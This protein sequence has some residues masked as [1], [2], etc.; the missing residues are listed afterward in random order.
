MAKKVR[1]SAAEFAEK[2]I[3]RTKAASTDMRAGVERVTEAPGK[4]AAVKQEKMKANLVAAIDSGKWARRTASVTLEDWKK[5]MLEKGV[6]RV[7]AGLDRAADKIEAFAEEL[8]VHE[9]ALLAK[10]G[11]M[12]DLTLQDSINRA[13]TWIEGMAKF[14]RKS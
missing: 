6:G 3:R 4:K 12:P 13:T 9:N 7:S 10:V 1:L 14:E 11:D 2:H 8:I 5:D